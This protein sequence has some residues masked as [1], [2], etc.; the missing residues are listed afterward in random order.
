MIHGLHRVAAVAA[1]LLASALLI[2]CGLRVGPQ[3]RIG[4]QELL[5]RTA[6]TPFECANYDPET[7]SCEMISRY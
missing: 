3:D 1:L 6:A 7:D 2:G 4:F 5:A